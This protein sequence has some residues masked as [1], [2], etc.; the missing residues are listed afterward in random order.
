M[1]F[2]KRNKTN[3][4]LVALVSA[5][6]A[7][8]TT[9]LVLALRARFK[10]KKEEALACDFEDCDCLFVDDEVEPLVDEEIPTEE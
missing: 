9:L 7:A 1:P 8:G 4:L 6:V 10:K 3:W 5:V 2:F